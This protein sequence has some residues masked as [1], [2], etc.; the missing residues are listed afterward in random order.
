MHNFRFLQIFFKIFR[1]SDEKL[2]GGGEGQKKNLS[3]NNINAMQPILVQ[4]HHKISLKHWVKFL[5]HWMV[6]F[7]Y[8]LDI[9]IKIYA[10]MHMVKIPAKWAGK[11]MK[12][13]KKIF[14]N[15]YE[16]LC[17]YVS[18]KSYQMIQKTF[19]GVENKKIKVINQNLHFRGFNLPLINSFCHWKFKL[20][21]KN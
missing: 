12:K 16:Y 19:H 11:K 6:T 2:G 20:S 4:I 10:K 14:F 7:F 15:F 1:L 8:N 5:R 3:K 13:I 21:S 17:V 9:T 18:K